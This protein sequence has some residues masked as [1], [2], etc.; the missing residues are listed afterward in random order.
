MFDDPETMRAEVSVNSEI[1]EDRNVIFTL[2][3]H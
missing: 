3:T 2:E 1:K